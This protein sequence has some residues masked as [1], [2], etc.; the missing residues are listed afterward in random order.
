MDWGVTTI[1]RFVGIQIGTASNERLNDLILVLF[2]TTSVGERGIGPLGRVRLVGISTKREELRND[3]E[4]AL[5]D[6]LGEGRVLSRKGV[7]EGGVVDVG[8]AGDCGRS[9]GLISSVKCVDELLSSVDGAEGGTHN[10][11][12][13]CLCSPGF[14]DAKRSLASAIEL[15]QVSAQVDH[16]LERIIGAS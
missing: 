9:G 8:D 6:S 12:Y 7:D 1:A 13:L 10:D 14:S 11:I 2:R 15:G 5:K 16:G 3:I 4:V